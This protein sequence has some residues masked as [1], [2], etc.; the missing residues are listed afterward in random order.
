[1]GMKN[2][3]ERTIEQWIS[4]IGS[5][6][7][8]FGLAGA[9]LLWLKTPIT[10]EMCLFWMAPLGFLLILVGAAVKDIRQQL[11]RHRAN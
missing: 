3:K 6:I 2:L 8:S 4:E 10:L 11:R 9:A 5:G 1:M 7:F